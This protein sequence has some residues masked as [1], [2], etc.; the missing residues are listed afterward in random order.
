MGQGLALIS[1]CCIFTDLCIISFSSQRKLAFYI[2][3]EE[4]RAF[5]LSFKLALIGVHEF[6][7][8]K[9]FLRVAN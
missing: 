2:I 3:F 5:T 7:L 8:P 6:Y 4:S 1:F 9:D